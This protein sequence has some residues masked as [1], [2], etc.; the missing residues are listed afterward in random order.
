[1]EKKTSS[2]SKSAEPNNIAAAYIR[3]STKNQEE[4]GFSIEVQREKA[5][6]YAKE[7]NLVL[8]NDMI[9]EETKPV[10]KTSKD[11]DE[12]DG[13]YERLKRRPALNEIIQLINENKISHLIIY[14]RDRLT[15]NFQDFIT[16]KSFFNKAGVTIHY[17][18]PGEIY[19]IE[20]TKINNFLELILASVAELEANTIGIRVKGG[21]RSCIKKGF[22]A[23][24]KVPFGFHSIHDPQNK[25]NSILRA[26]KY[27]KAIIEEIFNMYSEYGFGYRKISDFMNEKY[28]FIKWTKSKIESIIK[29]ETYTGY[30]VWDR[31]GGRRSPGKHQE[32]DKSPF[33]SEA[34]II[35]A[36]QWDKVTSL[37]KKKEILKDAKYF[38]TPF[39][40][41]GKLVCGICGSVMKC[42]NYGKGKKSVY[43]CPTLNTKGI[44]EM[45]IEKEEIEQYFIQELKKLFTYNMDKLWDLYSAR[46][47]EQ[48]N[49][50]MQMMKL[51]NKKL[52]EIGVL[53]G[54]IDSV[55]DKN[56][57]E[58]VKS[59][60]LEQRVMLNKKE[61]S[62]RKHYDE[63]VNFSYEKYNSKS[64]FCSALIGINDKVNM[65]TDSNKRMLFD[66]LVER[67]VTME[68]AGGFNIDIILNPP[69]EI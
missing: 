8:S 51:I 43:K 27:E 56:I 23:G 68:K 48:E 31:R 69:K 24:G 55:I 63:V 42:K 45:I 9:Y 11:D 34:C 60:I 65:S 50:N 14:T 18:R 39:I 3:V 38:N 13:F 26:D 5:I 40:L 16:L 20:D 2:K 58:P 15:R 1:M 7:K 21:N 54:R 33:L 66:I 49:N 46:L 22:W 47:K 67:I 32:H 30:I 41:R 6:S 4:K 62:L 44:A 61:Q 12:G 10:S 25:K 57:E 28:P 29:N 35:S 52:K 37:R 19:K 36:N 59:S 17:S 53:K 64:E